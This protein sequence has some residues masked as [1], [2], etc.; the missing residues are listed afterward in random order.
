M[1]IL[2]ILLKKWKSALKSPVEH[3]DVET[4]EKTTFMLLTEQADIFQVAGLLFQIKCRR[5]WFH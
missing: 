5:V 3:F 4:N 1:N 2:R